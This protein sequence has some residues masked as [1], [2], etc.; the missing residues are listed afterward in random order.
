MLN[1]YVKKDR[2]WIPR[3]KFVDIIQSYLN[4]RR[5]ALYFPSIND[6]PHE[7]AVIHTIPCESHYR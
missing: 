5:I 3:M 2:S 6:S 1:D 7:V 4:L